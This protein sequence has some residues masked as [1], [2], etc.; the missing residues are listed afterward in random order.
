[1]GGGGAGAAMGGGAGQGASLPPPVPEVGRVCE[2]G[3]MAQLSEIFEGHP[4]VLIDCW[5]PGC[6]PCVQIKP[7]FEALAASNENPNLVFARV[8]THAA[9]DVAQRYQIDAVPT[10]IAFVHGQPTGRVRGADERKLTQLVADLAQQVPE[11]KY[12]SARMHD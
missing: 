2:I 8:N 6:G 3:S 10:F 4:G 1:M 7:R 9:P 11:G 12:V 5:R